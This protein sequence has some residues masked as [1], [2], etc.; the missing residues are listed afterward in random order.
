M[1]QRRWRAEDADDDFLLDLS[2]RVRT[3][4]G[5]ITHIQLYK[6]ATEAFDG[7]RRHK[8]WRYRLPSDEWDDMRIKAATRVIQKAGLI[9]QRYGTAKLRAYVGVTVNN[10]IKNNLREVLGTPACFCTPQRRL[11]LQKAPMTLARKVVDPYASQPPE[12]FIDDMVS[13]CMA[14]CTKV[15]KSIFRSAMRGQ[16]GKQMA[17]TRGISQPVVSIH[18]KKVKQRFKSYLYQ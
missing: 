3:V 1:T 9:D 11:F 17:R 8:Y 2:R 6:W 5:M 14:A 7:L 18:L 4:G 15:E 13:H 10:S 16:T 12:R